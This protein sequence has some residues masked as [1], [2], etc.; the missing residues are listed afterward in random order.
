[1][2]E[3]LT[4]IRAAFDDVTAPVLVVAA[5]DQVLYAN[6]AAR[7]RGAQN[8]RLDKDSALAIALS[9]VLEA[10]EPARI[11]WGEHGPGGVL[12]WY[13]A[14]VSPL[15]AD[16][17][18]EGW[19][20]VS[21]E[22]TE[23]KRTEE[24]LRRTEKL[25]VDTQGVAHLGTWEW[26]V[27]EPHAFWSAELYRIYG[28]T[29]ETYTPSYE[30]YLQMV[31]PD[32]RQRV[33]DATNGVFNA[34]VPYSHDERIFWPDGSIRYLHTW[35]YPILDNEGRLRRLVGVCQDITERKQAEE[36]VRE[37]NA[38]LERRVTE[39]TRQLEA[40]LRDLEAFNAMV[41]HDLR[42]PLSTIEMASALISRTDPSSPNAQRAHARLRRATAQMATLIDDLLAFARIGNAPLQL[43]AVDV[44][45][46]AHELAGDLRQSSP[47]RS[48][49]VAIE[50]GI[51]CVADHGLMRIALQN[52]LA[53]AWKYT[54]RIEDARIELTTAAI[55][56]RPVLRVHDNGA[57]FDMKEAHRL[58][59]PFQRLHSET[60]FTGTGLGLASVHRILERHGCRVWA[61][62]TSGQGATFFVELPSLGEGDQAR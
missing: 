9:P 7:S 15:R 39:R 24:R 33:I 49:T 47:E 28:L 2:S 1:L 43:S 10:G 52:L 50:P 60:E 58:F 20:C 56:G 22:V 30:G 45:A 11:E 29:P 31:H 54:A 62:S 34:H 38:D 26:D 4:A 27:T 25:M 59:A 40:S 17:R 36:K 42:S 14:T 41:S 61:E 51:S 44:S 12:C 55:D 13:A 23:L 37:M 18:I 32:D 53:N 19:L 21:T 35:A 57:G 8:A 5:G 16:G 6:E 3:Y 46:M 48:I